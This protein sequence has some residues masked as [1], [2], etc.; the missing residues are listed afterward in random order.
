MGLSEPIGGIFDGN[1]KATL[2]GGLV[3]S[4]GHFGNLGFC[5]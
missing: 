4:N 2:S 1:G 3:L 5:F